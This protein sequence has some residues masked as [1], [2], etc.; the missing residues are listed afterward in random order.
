MEPRCPEFVPD[1]SLS[2]TAMETMQREIADAAVFE[3]EFDFDQAAVSAR[4]TLSDTLAEDGPGAGPDRSATPGGPVVAGVDAAF[5]DGSVDGEEDEGDAG[6]GSTG[7]DG[8]SGE[9]AVGAVVLSRGGQVLERASAVVDCGFPYVPGLLSF[10]EAGAV[11]AAFASL[12]TEP[13]LALFDGSG[14]IHYRQAG[15]ATHLGVVLDLP[16]IGVAK[17]LL[18]GR[19]REPLDALPAGARVAVEAGEEITAPDGS[20]LPAETVVGYALQTRQYGSGSRTINPIYV[21]SGHRVG[22]ETAADLVERLCT[23]YKLPEP[24]RLADRYAD[25]TKGDHG[26]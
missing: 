13:D 1:P 3:D 10:R 26:A 4:A 14:R 6:E 25:E 11:L 2:R 23:D 8:G 21:S 12:E 5:L 22:T 7:G 17:G 20:A 24:T 9:R 15:L 16:G 19:P 18:C